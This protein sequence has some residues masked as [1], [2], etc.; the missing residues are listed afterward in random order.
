FNYPDSV[1]VKEIGGFSFKIFYSPNSIGSSINIGK[2][3]PFRNLFPFEFSNAEEVIRRYDDILAVIKSWPLFPKLHHYFSPDGEELFIALLP[4]KSR[5]RDPIYELLG[6]EDLHE[7]SKKLPWDNRQNTIN[8]G[9]SGKN[10]LKLSIRALKK[11]IKNKQPL[12]IELRFQCDGGCLRVYKHNKFGLA[13]ATGPGDWLSFDIT[14]LQGKTIQSYHTDAMGVKRPH[15]MDFV[16][17]TPKKPYIETVRIYLH[18]GS[19]EPFP[20]YGLYKIKAHYFYKHNP[21]WTDDPGL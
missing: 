1:T 7:F 11:E 4:V 5:D 20:E 16:D 8:T 9:H 15:R 6:I 18:P 10:M 14:S 19:K 17:I 3:G 12:D 13:S 21:G 2:K